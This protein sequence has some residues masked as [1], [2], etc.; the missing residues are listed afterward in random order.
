MKA[1]VKHIVARTYQPWVKKYLTKTRHYR[2]GRL[3]L[4]IPPQVFHPGFFFSTKLL[5]SHINKMPLK[6]RLLLELGC[7]SGLISL[8]AAR[9]GALVTASDINPVAIASLEK[10]GGRNNISL[11]VVESDLF[12]QIP[13]ASFDIIAINPPYYKKDPGSYAEHAWFCGTNGEYF[14]RL[15]QQLPGYMLPNTT[16]L[17][18]LF[19]GCDMGMINAYAAAEHLFLRPVVRKKNLLEEN[20]I[21]QVEKISK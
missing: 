17:M 12:N 3:S 6:G 11:T 18:V 15:F 10:N 2:Y 8:E 13:T 9:R 16:V 19:D 4:E 5:L 20:T 21:Y 1:L 7:G 14:Q